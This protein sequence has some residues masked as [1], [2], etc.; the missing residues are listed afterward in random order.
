MNLENAYSLEHCKSGRW[1]SQPLA[2]ASYKLYELAAGGKPIPDYA[3]QVVDISGVT[4]TSLATMG[5]R[6]QLNR[7]SNSTGYDTCAFFACTYLI[8]FHQ[9]GLDVPP[10]ND[11]VYLL[12]PSKICFA[13]NGARHNPLFYLCLYETDSLRRF[14]SYITGYVNRLINFNLF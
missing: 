9:Q 8:V 12:Q 6:P 14:I 3:L 4:C 7:S 11:L 1:N 13:F 5:E 10:F 2:S